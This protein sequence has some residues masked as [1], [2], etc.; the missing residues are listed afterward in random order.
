MAPDDQPGTLIDETI[1]SFTGRG[2][3]LLVECLV[4]AGVQVIFGLPGDTGVMFYD[5]LAQRTG[6]VRHVLTRD[7]RHAAIMADAYARATNEVG[8]VEVSSGGGCTYVIGGLGEAYASGVP[9]LVI[10]SDIHESS[11]GSGALTEIDQIA[12][13]SAVTKWS[14]RVDVAADIPGLL[15]EAMAQATTG[16]P[17]PVALIIAENVLD[18]G[19]S[20]LD[21]RSA[22]GRT[23]PRVPAHRPVPQV[24]EVETAAALIADARRPVLYAGSGVHSS[25]AA[26][27]LLA[28]AEKLSAPVATSIH[29]KGAIPETH[30]LSLGVAGNNGGSPPANDALS[31]ADVVLFV[32]TRANATDTNSFRSP[33]RSGVEVIHLDIDRSRAGRNYPGSLP[34]VGDAAATLRE[35]VKKVAGR[36]T[37]PPWWTGR[38][39]RP[40]EFPPAPEGMIIPEEVVRQVAAVLGSDMTVVADPGTPTPNVAAYWTCTA[41]GR[42]VLIPRGHGPMGWAIPAAVGAALAVPDRPVVGFTADGSF[43]MASG[44]LETIARLGLPICL[45]QMTNNSFGWIKMLQHLYAEKRYFGVDPGPIDA[46]A[47]AEAS[48]LRALRAHDSEELREALRAF[49]NAPSPL[50]VDVTVPHMIDYLPPVPF[51]RDAVENGGAR[52]VY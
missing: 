31:E 52:P 19:V 10:S 6:D 43:A 40:E 20:G 5:A 7:E 16:R 37:E 42:S 34:L 48:G 11:R 46:V 24:D 17:G 1:T 9:V 50:Y 21:L 33:P 29:G 14:A 8:V 36:R 4:T 38:A 12:L 51:W 26:N 44:E 13:F 22:P 45:I 32:G 35:L 47:V 3:D 15:S 27:E 49:R 2:A 23:T 41:P 28:L 25:G 30:E 39:A 18:E